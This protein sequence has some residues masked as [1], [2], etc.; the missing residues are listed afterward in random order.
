MENELH[1][2]LKLSVNNLFTKVPLQNDDQVGFISKLISNYL[3]FPKTGS[4]KNLNLNK[5]T[6]QYIMHM[7]HSDYSALNII[8]QGRRCGIVV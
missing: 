2:N 6:K 8:F 4:V 7:T 3:F 5:S 1:C